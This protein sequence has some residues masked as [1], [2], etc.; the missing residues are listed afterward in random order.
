MQGWVQTVPTLNPL[1]IV[2]LYEK[3]NGEHKIFNIT[4][5]SSPT[6]SLAKRRGF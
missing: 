2:T 5:N 4:L 1:Q 3:Q 6:P